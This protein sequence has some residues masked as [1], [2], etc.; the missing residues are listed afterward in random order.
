MKSLTLLLDN[1]GKHLRIDNKTVLKQ[2]ADFHKS[3]EKEFPHEVYSQVLIAYFND[4]EW[5]DIFVKCA[6]SYVTYDP[7]FRFDDHVTIILEVTPSGV[8]CDWEITKQPMTTEDIRKMYDAFLTTRPDL[9]KYK[10]EQISVK[11][12]LVSE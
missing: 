1:N 6:L 10:I 9:V 12:L 3:E 5:N 11:N 7:D 4:I 8:H 2:L